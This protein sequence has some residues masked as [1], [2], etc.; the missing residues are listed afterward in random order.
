M[1]DH[2][3]LDALLAA[4]GPRT[5]LVY[6]A[7]PEQPDGDDDDA[8][9]S[10]TPT[11]IASPSTCSRFSTRR[12]SSTSSSRTTRTASRSTCKRGRR[13]LVLRTFSKIYGLAGLRVGYGV[14]PAD[15]IDG[16]RQDAPR[17]STSTTQAQVARAREH[18][19]RRRAR[20]APAADRRGTAHARARRC[21]STGSSPA[22]PGGR[23]TSS[24]SEVGEDARGR[25]SRR[26][27][28]SGAIVRPMGAIRR[29]GALTDHG[30]D[31]PDENAF[32]AEAARAS[33]HGRDD[34]A[35]GYPGALRGCARRP[36]FPY[37]DD[38]EE[39]Q[40]A[41]ARRIERQRPAGAPARRRSGRSR[42]TA[43]RS[44]RS[45][46]AGATAPHGARDGLRRAPRPRCG[47]SAARGGAYLWSP[48]ERRRS[49][50]ARRPT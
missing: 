44:R 21:A 22:G 37:A 31:A 43:S 39:R 41:A 9:A 6:V 28:A 32:F 35:V 49:R 12:T 8:R 25:S 4:I 33:V 45:A 10:S 1:D 15:V 26:C 36:R 38:A 46:R 11:S 29:P 48:R 24:S 40:S 30:R 7:D 16:D 23:R 13:V 17:R 5:K 19:P 18:R 3:D 42:S 2:Y 27:S 50:R 47:R 14:G 34:L 20:R